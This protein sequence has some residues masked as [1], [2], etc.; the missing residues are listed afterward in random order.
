ME[1]L[2]R[3]PY[4]G[5]S[6]RR[7]GA[8]FVYQDRAVRVADTSVK[9]D[10]SSFSDVNSQSANSFY[11]NSDVPIKVFGPGVLATAH[12]PFSHS[13]IDSANVDSS[14]VQSAQVASSASEVA[15]SSAAVVENSNS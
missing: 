11:T 15:A 13:A 7:S 1:M 4:N 2:F 3:T 9:Q 8:P 6:F 14:S 5:D 10:G 12:N